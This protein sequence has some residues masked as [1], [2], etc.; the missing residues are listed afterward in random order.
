MKRTLLLAILTVIVST[1]VRAQLCVDGRPVVYDS[2]SN[3]MMVSIPQENFGSSYRARIT[4]S[5][6]WSSLKING[7]SV[8]EYYTFS[9]VEGGKTYSLTVKNPQ[10]FVVTSKITFT[11]LPILELQGDFGYDYQEGTVSLYMPGG[12]VSTEMTGVLKWRGGSTN[13]EG[14]HKRNYKIKFSEDQR[15]FNLRKDN[16]WILDAGQ[17]DLFRLR[18]RVATELWLQMAR[19]PYYSAEEPE[20]RSGVRGEVV[21]LVLNNEYRGIYCLTEAMDR[22]QMKLKKYDDA[23]GAIHGGLWK[24]TDWLN[25]TM[26]RTLSFYDNRSPEWQSFEVKYPKLD[27]VEETDY[28]TLYNAIS[29]VATSSDANFK[30]HV[31]EYF[32]MPVIIDYYIFV[33]VM[34]A[35]DN[36]GKNMYWAVYDKEKDK[37]LTPAVWDLDGTVGAKWLNHWVRG[38]Y[39]SSSPEYDMKPGMYLYER[40][41]KLNACDFNTLVTQRYKELRKTVLSTDNLV[42]LY[43]NYFDRIWKSGAAQRETAVWSEDT[44]ID[45]ETLDFEYEIYYISYWLVRRLKYLDETLFRSDDTATGI[46]TMPA[47]DGEDSPFYTVSGQRTTRPGATGIYIRDGRK[48]VVKMR[49]ER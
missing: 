29:F 21:E 34:A 26:Y 5:E 31:A 1:A 3:T 48:Y 23:T 46:A 30:A 38:S 14:K 20:A 4:L 41:I 32:D 6:G 10:K 9:S 43:T 18:N 2:E 49:G 17:V 19:K 27:D 25:S 33:Y 28:S 39:G 7:S 35:M 44:D 11:F 13:G 40:L 12:E 15:F 42:S 37:R 47:T 36:T 45:G 8:G 24:S 22:K 16:K